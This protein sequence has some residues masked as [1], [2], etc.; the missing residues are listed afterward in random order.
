MSTVE[1]TALD[2]VIVGWKNIFTEQKGWKA[3]HFN[4]KMLYKLKLYKMKVD[5][6]WN[7]KESNQE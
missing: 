4:H 7:K 3:K 1:S 2:E 5:I 6:K